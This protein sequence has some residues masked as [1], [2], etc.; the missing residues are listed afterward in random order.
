MPAIL[1]TISYIIII[2][3]FKRSSL[4]LKKISGETHGSL[5]AANRRG[6]H[7]QQRLFGI[8]L[9][10][11]LRLI[12]SSSNPNHA[13]NRFQPFRDRRAS[14]S[15][16]DLSRRPI[17]D[18]ATSS[19]ASQHDEDKVF[20]PIYDKRRTFK[21]VL[22]SSALPSRTFA[23]QQVVAAAASNNGQQSNSKCEL[24]NPA[25]DI[26]STSM[27]RSALEFDRWRSIFSHK[28]GINLDS[29]TTAAAAAVSSR[30]RIM[31]TLSNIK[32]LPQQ[33][34]KAAQLT[35]TGLQV[36][37]AKMSFY[38]ILLWV[39]SWTPIASL[40][41][42][43][44]V[45]ECA[46]A[47]ATSVFLASTMTKLGPAL[48]VFIYGIAHPKIKSRFKQIMRKLLFLGNKAQHM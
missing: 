2:V 19:V 9:R 24:D 12:G 6:H 44:S 42:I 32:I 8:Q 29:A 23:Q 31:K 22:S 36:R 35:R 21:R 10:N 5:L 11:S 28:S 38:L 13:H 34:T 20:D 30:P 16:L 3:A 47:S 17:V 27:Q 45:M 14:A 46:Q 37:L 39:V 25:F 41:M 48:D 15:V 33:A 1:I 40:A 26:S 18:Q 7:Q 43:N 4:D